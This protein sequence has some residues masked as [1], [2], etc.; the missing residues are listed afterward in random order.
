MSCQTST[1]ILNTPSNSKTSTS[2]DIKASETGNIDFNKENVTPISKN[3][4][5]GSNI[6]DSLIIW[7]RTFGERNSFSSKTVSVS[8]D[9]NNPSF[10][11]KIIFSKDTEPVFLHKD[12]D[13]F[14]SISVD[15]IKGDKRWF[16]LPKQMLSSKELSLLSVV[17]N[18]YNCFTTDN[19]VVF[20]NDFV[21]VNYNYKCGTDGM[22]D[23]TINPDFGGTYS[24][25][26]NERG[27]LVY[28]TN[29]IGVGYIQLISPDGKF[30]YRMNNSIKSSSLDI[31][32]LATKAE[33]KYNTG[34]ILSW[35]LIRF[36]NSKVI[37]G[38]KS[39][40]QKVNFI[41][42]DY[43]SNTLN[44]NNDAINYNPANA[45]FDFR[46]QEMIYGV[47]DKDTLVLSFADFQKISL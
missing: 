12:Y 31:I 45:F 6:S 7:N 1:S 24:L 43:S 2:S 16:T 41:L 9:E 44:I 35:G 3:L 34:K 13:I 27:D 17:E 37:F 23:E 42:H 8:M 33:Y 25:I 10:V 32:N 5:A 39:A 36:A 29:G 30:A 11:E 20:P 21:L 4:K 26:F 28:K 38:L 18:V 46:N 22:F 19:I 14:N 15:S 40:P 47:I